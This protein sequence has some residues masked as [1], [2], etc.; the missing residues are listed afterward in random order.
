MKDCDIDVNESGSVVRLADASREDA[1]KAA[2]MGMPIR[3]TIQ[4]A[5]ALTRPT[6]LP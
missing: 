4:S 6:G 5:S 3:Y 1:V 2:L